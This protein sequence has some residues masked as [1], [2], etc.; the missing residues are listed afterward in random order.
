MSGGVNR[1]NKWLIYKLHDILQ[2][3]LKF[4]TMHDDENVIVNDY[5]AGE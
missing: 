5:V 4:P 3:M 1:V 2:K